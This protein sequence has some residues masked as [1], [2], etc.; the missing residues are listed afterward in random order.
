MGRTFRMGNALYEIVGVAEGPSTGT[1]PG[2]I[3]DIFV[4]AIMH[5]DVSNSNSSWFRTW[6]R[7]KPGV[8]REPVRQKLEA[9]FRAF[10]EERGKGLAGIPKERFINVIR[11]VQVLEP[12]AAGVSEMQN[13]NRRH[14]Q[15]SVL[16]WRW[17]CSLRVRTSQILFMTAQ[18][19]A[20]A[21]E[22][23]LRI[24]IGAGRWRLVQLVLMESFWIAL[25]ASALGGFSLGGRCRL[26]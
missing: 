1:E 13:N 20:G 9:T 3:T 16:W 19:A 4:P 17:C 2:T 24:S 23:A 11:Q 12:A 22:M 8:A 18:A 10:Q 15:C 26:L 14:S 21:R 7:L 25:L 6:A 5:P